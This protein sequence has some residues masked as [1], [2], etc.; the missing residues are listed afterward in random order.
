VLTALAAV[1]IIAAVAFGVL[2]GGQANAGDTHTHVHFQHVTIEP[3]ET[4]WQLATEEAPSSDPRNF[5][6][7]VVTLNNLPSAAVQA[8]QR[9]AIPTKYTDGQ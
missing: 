4:L 2:N 5:I 3:G 7:D 8:G 6:Q 1:P 9:L